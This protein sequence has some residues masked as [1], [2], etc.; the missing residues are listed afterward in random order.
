MPGI[1]RTPTSHDGGSGWSNP[2]YAYDDDLGT[3][4][5]VWCSAYT[6]TAFLNLYHSV[7]TSTKVRL[8]LHSDFRYVTVDVDVRDEN[9]AWHDVYQGN[10]VTEAWNEFPFSEMRVDAMR[11]RW[12]STSFTATLAD[13]D[14]ADFWQVITPDLDMCMP[15][16]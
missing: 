6:W 13:L 16:R 10:F 9:G 4:A 15:R 3:A 11:L 2:T 1:W 7:I 14:E 12:Y 8:H 5:S